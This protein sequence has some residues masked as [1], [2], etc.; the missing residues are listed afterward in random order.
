VYALL[1]LGHHLFLLVQALEPPEHML[2]RE[3]VVLHQ[4]FHWRYLQLPQAGKKVLK[5]RW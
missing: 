4:A 1:P 2:K 5:R 3:L